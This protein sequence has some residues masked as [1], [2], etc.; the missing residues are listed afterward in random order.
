MDGA[1]RRDR[2]RW[3]V[4]MVDLP[5]AHGHRRRGGARRLAAPRPCRPRLRHDRAGHDAAPAR[6]RA[7]PRAGSGA[8]ARRRRQPRAGEPDHRHQR[9][10]AGRA[11]PAA[12]EAGARTAGA[13]DGRLGHHRSDV[14]HPRRRRARLHR[15]RRGRARRRGPLGSTVP[16]PRRRCSGLRDDGPALAPAV[17]RAA[18]GLHR[19]A[20]AGRHLGSR[21]RDGGGA[22]RGAGCHGLPGRASRV[23]QPPEPASRLPRRWRRA[24]RPRGHR[25]AR[26]R[27][28]RG[29]SRWA[30]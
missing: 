13:P 9:E 14:R 30:S 4:R 26:S 5:G 21:D 11:G 24:R 3:G 19:R 12:L 6:G 23:P 2:C 8:R 27:C 20:L 22:A 28:S 17:R 7:V 29:W 16:P 25:R 18:A 1:A 10:P 15:D